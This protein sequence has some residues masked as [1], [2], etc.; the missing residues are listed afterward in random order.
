MRASSWMRGRSCTHAQLPTH[1]HTHTHTR[2]CRHALDACLHLDVRGRSRRPS[3]ALRLS[4][5]R[6]PRPQ[7]WPLADHRHPAGA[8]SNHLQSV[9][10]EV[11]C[12]R[13]VVASVLLVVAQIDDTVAYRLAPLAC[14]D[15]QRCACRQPPAVSC[16]WS[17]ASGQ[18]RQLSVGCGSE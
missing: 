4:K 11:G 8:V 14:H 10:C 1:T 17:G 13:S 15:H 9:A 5:R 18:L 16:V 6:S 12:V 2:T 3:D 7:R